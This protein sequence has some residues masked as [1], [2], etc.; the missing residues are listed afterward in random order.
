M[1]QTHINIFFLPSIQRLGGRNHYLAIRYPIVLIKLLLYFKI[2]LCTRKNILL[3][4]IL[5][6]VIHTLYL[7]LIFFYDKQYFIVTI[8]FYE[9]P[10]P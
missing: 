3:H 1:T 6:L 4:S 2:K 7:M 5:N 10:V 8:K 9:C